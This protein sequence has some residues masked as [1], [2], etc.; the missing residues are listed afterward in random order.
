MY[1]KLYIYSKTSLYKVVEYLNIFLYTG[2]YH[3]N[4]P[5]KTSVNQK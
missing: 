4:L 3:V 1:N 2:I 5:Y